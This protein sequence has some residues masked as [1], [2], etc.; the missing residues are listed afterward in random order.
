MARVGCVSRFPRRLQER[1]VNISI[2]R[3]RGRPIRGSRPRDITCHY[4]TRPKAAWVALGAG[5]GLARAAT[6]WRARSSAIIGAGILVYGEGNVNRRWCQQSA[7]A[8]PRR[9][10]SGLGDAG[11]SDR[12]RRSGWPHRRSKPKVREDLVH[13]AGDLLTMRRDPDVPSLLARRSL[14]K[15]ASDSLVDRLLGGLLV[16][17]KS[18]RWIHFKTI[19]SAIRSIPKIHASH[20]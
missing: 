18:R 5:K 20:A 4:R 2:L 11:R 13:E 6:A 10:G 19:P 3:P 1:V 16:V 17:R 15:Q 14:G 7:R 12:R 9:R 8:S